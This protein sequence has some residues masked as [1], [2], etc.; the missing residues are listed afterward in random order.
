[1]NLAGFVFL[2]QSAGQGNGACDLEILDLWCIVCGVLRCR[3]ENN[4]STNEIGLFGPAR[5]IRTV[6]S[7]QED[8]ESVG[9]VAA[10]FV[11][12]DIGDVFST[13]RRRVLNGRVTLGEARF[14]LRC[15]EIKVSFG[16]QIIFAAR[17]ATVELVDGC[18]HIGHA[19]VVDQL[20]IRVTEDCG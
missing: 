5:G 15:I 9:A 13:L 20:G 14:Y 10:E 19:C 12:G 8:V 7:T 2:E 4:V 16:K 3:R 6:E 17:V 1:M 18:L 11:T